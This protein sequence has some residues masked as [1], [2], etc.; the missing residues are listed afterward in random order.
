MR[1]DLVQDLQVII[2]A[3][4]L[5]KPAQQGRK[6][7]LDPVHI[8]ELIC[9]RPRSAGKLNLFLPCGDFGQVAWKLACGVQRPGERVRG[10]GCFRS[11]TSGGWHEAAIPVMLAIDPIAAKP[12]GSAPS[13]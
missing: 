5:R 1:G 3:K 13:P 4:V 8:L 11:P 2:L 9:A 6:R 7:T 10:A 12:G